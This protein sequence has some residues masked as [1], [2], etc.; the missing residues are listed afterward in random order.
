M[1]FFLTSVLIALPLIIMYRPEA[2]GSSKKSDKIRPHGSDLAHSVK[3]LR[4][5]SLCL[6]PAVHKHQSG[7]N[8]AFSLNKEL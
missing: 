7:F 1:S 3:D 2:T 4:D 6:T 5:H 8:I